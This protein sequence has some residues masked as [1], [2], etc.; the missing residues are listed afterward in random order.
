MGQGERWSQ[1]WVFGLTIQR[2]LCCLGG[3]TMFAAK[4]TR[5]A[6]KYFNTNFVDPWSDGPRL[7]VEAGRRVSL[8]KRPARVF[9]NGVSITKGNGFM[10][11]VRYFVM[12]RL[13]QVLTAVVVLSTGL[14]A[15]TIA[16]AGT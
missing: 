7:C 9:L 13:G 5:P 10:S 12:G 15:L 6:C 8:D 14:A 11:I 4:E 1:L 16:K 2:S 3:S